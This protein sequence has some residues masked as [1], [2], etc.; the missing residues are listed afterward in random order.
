MYALWQ[1]GLN[2]EPSYATAVVL[3]V[4]VAGLNALSSFVA[5]K[6]TR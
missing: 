2:V 4:I 1:E 6:V 3:L 5:R